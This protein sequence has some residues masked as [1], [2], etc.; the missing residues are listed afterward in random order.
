MD[1]N[2]MKKYVDYFNDNRSKDPAM[3]VYDSFKGYLKA[4]VKNKFHESDVHLMVIPGRLT[5][6]CQP[7][8]VTI[9]V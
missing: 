5:G 2:L 9:T 1:V 8:D 6:I 7:L 4:S 3:L